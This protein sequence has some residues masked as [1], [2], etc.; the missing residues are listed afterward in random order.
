MLPGTLVLSSVFL[1]QHSVFIECRTGFLAFFLGESIMDKRRVPARVCVPLAIA[2]LLGVP[3]LTGCGSKLAATKPVTGTVLYRG[4]PV[5]GANVL[6]SRGSRNIAAGEIAMGKTDTQG[7][8]TLTTHFGSQTDSKGAPE[9]Q[10]EV[11]V[12]KHVPPKG[13][14]D[15]QY[16]AMVEAANKIGETGAM[17]PPDKQPPA[18]VEMFPEQYST[19]G[20]SK[21]TATVSTQGAN[22][23]QFNLE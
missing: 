9:G 12:S 13:V 19:V 8:F 7:R 1:I 16:Q 22:D 15:S 18:L 17:V 14:S 10:Y 3:W 20:K 2:C 11:T 5:E 21:L 6:F 4:N 23:F